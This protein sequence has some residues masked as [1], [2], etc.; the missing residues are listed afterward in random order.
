MSSK[1][2]GMRWLKCDL[3]VQ[4]PEDSAHW[5]DADLALNNPRRPK[6]AGVPDESFIQEKARVFLRRCHELSLDVIGITDHNF[7]QKTDP[8]DWFL[9]HLVEQNKGIAKELDRNPLVIFPGFEVDI[10]YHVLC[11]FPAAKKQAQLEQCNR[12]LTKLGLAESDRFSSGSP[13]LL[14]KDGQ[15]ISLKTLISLVQGEM[16]GIVI[17]A[18]SD[19]ASGMLEQSIYREDFKHPDLYCVEVTQNPPAQRY[20][21]ILQGRNPGWKR[22]GFYPAWIM[23]SDA[24][25]LKTDEDGSPKPNSLGYRHT[26]MKM[27]APSI[28]SLRQAFLDPSSRIKLPEGGMQEKHPESF[29]DFPYIKSVRV[30]NAV[31][32]KDQEIHFSPNKTCLIGGRGSGK[33]TVLEYLR[34]VLGKDHEARMD[35]DSKQKA[36]RIKRTT[37][38]PEFKAVVEYQQRN[39]ASYTLQLSSGGVQV[40]EQEVI[41]LE[42]FLSGLPAQFFSQQQLNKITQTDEKGQLKSS[43]MLLGLVD[44]FVA[45]ELQVLQADI[46]NLSDTIRHKQEL[47]KEQLSYTLRAAVL[48]QEVRDLEQQWQARKDVQSDAEKHEALKKEQSYFSSLTVLVTVKLDQLKTEIDAFD[49]GFTSFVHDDTP[50]SAWFKQL[51]SKISSMN[52][53]L[54]VDLTNVIV[55]H[56]AELETVFADDK[57]WPSIEASIDNADAEF[58]QA[59]ASKGIQPEDIKQLSILAEQRS[60]KSDEILRLGAESQKL[61]DEV[62]DLENL[63]RALEGVW[64]KQYQLR[65][66]AADKANKLAVYE[67][68]NKSFVTVELRYQGD[69]Q[70][71]LQAWEEFG[72]KDKRA[73]L[74]REW[75]DLIGDCFDIVISNLSGS[76]W[77]ALYQELESNEE[78]AEVKNYIDSNPGEWSQLITRRVPDA[79]DITLYRADGSVAGKISD[80]TLSDGQRNTA[81][82]ALLLAQDGGPLIIDQPEDELDSNF[83][84]NELIPMIRRMK[85]K[86]QLIFATHNANLPVNG[87]ADLVY[88]F[89]AENAK[90]VCKAE[91][92]LDRADVTK[93]VLEIMEG[94]EKAFTRRREKYGF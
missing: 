11:L 26:W 21:D 2:Q 61:A 50:H 76:V 69:K 40:L 57:Q 70:F 63:Q 62:Q 93:A 29:N 87:D 12:N 71:F 58:Q 8:R 41:D 28:E 59:C 51:D 54:K 6:M 48:K 1:Y 23:S 3:Q 35:A 84:F 85:M 36:E 38:Q 4:T 22:E 81:V 7:S 78:L 31:F 94:S 91:G 13:S 89:E 64:F 56:V 74:A 90:G 86:R 79:I 80:S 75:C 9:T 18:H 45:D 19:Q 72:P 88:A 60:Q 10:G 17:A 52:Q 55:Q 20:L 47:K 77:T 83:V 67:N 30:E 92:G 24:K 27:S 66:Q 82:L 68:S 15:N 49:Q 37:Q 39:G 73:K 46:K 32:L 25:S 53:Q 14:R 65:N 5:A 33:S 42:T 44:G 16:G 34:V 43:E